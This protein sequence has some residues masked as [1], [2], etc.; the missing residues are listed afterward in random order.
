MQD[1]NK[2]Q[3]LQSQLFSRITFVSGGL[4]VIVGAIALVIAFIYHSPVAWGL[5]I[6][7]DGML[8]PLSYVTHR[9]AKQG[10]L[11]KSAITLA[12]IWYA[13]AVGMIIVGERLYGILLVTATLPVLMNLPYM[14]QR[15]LRRLIMTSIGLV[16]V[17]SVGSLFPPIITPTVPD[18]IIAVVEAFSTLTITM[19]VMLAIWQSAGKLND[20]SEG[21]QKAIEAL[22]ESERSLETK[23]EERTEELQQALKETADLNEIANVVNSTLDVNEVKDIIYKGL[24]GLFAFDQMGVFLLDEESGLLKLRLQAGRPFAAELHE[25][26][27]DVGLPVDEKDN[28]PAAAV[29]NKTSIFTGKISSDA[30]E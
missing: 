7:I 8:V 16:F 3:S 25:R 1:G 4:F 24:Q 23:V 5:A 14:S 28:L 17:G 27:I 26:F 18:D 11:D 29:V 22:K 19:V 9:W 13:I 2:P 21:M 10:L 30:V 20:A 6:L 15:V 12:G